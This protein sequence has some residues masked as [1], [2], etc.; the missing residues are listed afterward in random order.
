[1]EN[2]AL[3]FHQILRTNII[4]NNKSSFTIYCNHISELLDYK[5][6]P[7]NENRSRKNYP[8]FNKTIQAYCC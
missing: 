4:V 6:N 2:F 3:I 8:V 1:M 7:E 5:I